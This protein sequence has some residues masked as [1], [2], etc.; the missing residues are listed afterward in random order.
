MSNEVISTYERIDQVIAT[1][2][3]Q[4]GEYHKDMEGE[5]N[6]LSN[7]LTSLSI[8]WQGEDYDRFAS[9][10]NDKIIQIKEQ[11]KATEKLEEYLKEVATEFKQYLDQLKEAGN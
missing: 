10:I 8:G 3:K 4:V 7:A 2:A 1:F 6:N 11:L 9:S 5:I